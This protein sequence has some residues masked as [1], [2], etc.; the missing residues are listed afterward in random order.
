MRQ[1]SPG[2]LSEDDKDAR[3]PIMA[4]A[5]GAFPTEDLSRPKVKKMSDTDDR[6]EQA[7]LAQLIVSTLSLNLRPSDIDVDAP[8]FGEGLGLDSIDILEISLAVSQTY[9]VK[10]RS[11]DE[12][13]VSIFSSLRALNTHIQQHRVR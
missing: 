4:P 3:T 7:K 8:L 2:G 5:R 11:D 6:Q 9:G 13:N 12:R 10:L 1:Q